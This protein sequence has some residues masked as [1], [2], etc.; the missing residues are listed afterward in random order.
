VLDDQRQELVAEPLHLD[1]AHARDLEQVV[2]GPGAACGDLHERGVVED[3]VGGDVTGASL[4]LA[5]AL[6]R[7]DQRGV[8][9]RHVGG[10]AP[11][12]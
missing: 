11:V 5:P 4:V 6:E 7:V 12:G 9:V 8:L 2:A 3:H 10:P 1:R